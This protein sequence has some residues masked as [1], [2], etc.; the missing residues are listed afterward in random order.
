MGLIR[1]TA[2]ITWNYRST[3]IVLLVPALS[4][5]LLAVNTGPAKGGW[6]VIIMATYWI[7]EALPLAATSLIPLVL[8]PILGILSMDDVSQIY[9][10]RTVV[11]FFGS[12]V[13]AVAI[14]EQKVHKRIAL[15]T[16]LVMGSK[17]RW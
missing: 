11:L 5:P 9:F 7:T 17:P 1:E 13:L 14:E 8:Y 16:L 10:K 15:R 3:L 2:R 12:M 4:S 6:V